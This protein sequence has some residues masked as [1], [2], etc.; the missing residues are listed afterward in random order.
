MTK[1]HGG[2]KHSRVSKIMLHLT[3]NVL[4]VNHCCSNETLTHCGS[5]NVRHEQ[6]LILEQ[7]AVSAENLAGNKIISTINTNPP[8]FNKMTRTNPFVIKGSD[9]S[10]G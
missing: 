8:D 3:K 6:R 4:K 2:E 1:D 10:P 9:T 7:G 5:K